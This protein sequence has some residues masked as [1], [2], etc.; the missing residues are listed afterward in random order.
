[1][2][3]YQPRTRRVFDKSYWRIDNWQPIAKVLII[4]WAEK[5]KKS[6]KM[7]DVP[8]FCG[9]RAIRQALTD[10]VEEGYLTRKSNTDRFFTYTLVP[11]K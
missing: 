1:M 6:F 9:I 8:R 11:L 4:D 10:L 2:Y 3:Q 7:L 5:R